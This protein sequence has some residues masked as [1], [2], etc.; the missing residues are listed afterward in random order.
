MIAKIG[1][2]CYSRAHEVKSG[3]W[4]CKTWRLERDRT[5]TVVEQYV[6]TRE[7]ANRWCNEAITVPSFWGWP[8]TARP[9]GSDVGYL[10]VPG[11]PDLPL[12]EKRWLH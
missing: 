11:Q 2:W 10:G 5:E 12:E 3:R 4:R 1:P 8:D 7:Q 9:K 6:E